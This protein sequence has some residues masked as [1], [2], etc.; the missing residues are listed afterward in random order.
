MHVQQYWGSFGLHQESFQLDINI[1][2]DAI[3]KNVYS[4]SQCINWSSVTFD[5]VLQETNITN[6]KINP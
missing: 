4:D 5:C 3:V 6:S 2:Y 1:V